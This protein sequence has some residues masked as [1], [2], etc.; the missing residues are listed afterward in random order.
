MPPLLL[1]AALAF[2]GWQTGN[3]LVGAALALA[4]EGA[5]RVTLRFDLGA[6][7]HSRIADL[8]TVVFV[9]VAAILAANRGIARGILEAFIWL[10]AAL[11]PILLAQ[12]LSESGRI[13]LSALFRYLRKMK[14]ENPAMKDPPVEVSAVFLAVA[15][16]AAGVANDRGP[17]YYAG[18][19]IAVAWA[20]YP[21]RP[22]H[23]RLAAWALMLAA[24]VG[25]GHAGH[26]GLAQLQLLVG[27]WITDWHM[28][29]MDADP[30]RTSTDIGTLGRL[31]QYD[32]IALRVYVPQKDA[33]RVRLLHRASYNSYVGTSWQARSA[34]METM[35][36][37]ADGATWLLAPAGQEWSAR[38]ATRLERGK[39]LLALP[40]G[41]TRITGLPASA[42]RRNALGAVHADVGGDWIHYEAGG[43]AAIESYAP[44]SALDEQLPPAE[45]ATLERV[46]AQLGLRD[47]TGEEAL[48]RV[49]RYLG[50]FAYSTFRERAVPR[51]ETALGDFLTRTRAGHCEYFAAAATLLLRAGGVPARYATGFAVMEYSALEAAFV[52]RARHA[53]SWTRA[54][55]GGRWIELDTTP[56]SW[57]EEEERLAPFWQGLAD[58]VRWAGFRWSQRGEF[59]AGDAWY[60]VLALL[61]AILAWRLLR[62]RR[63]VRPGQ[64]GAAQIVQSRQG[65]DSEFY[66]VEQALARRS[67][68]RPAGEALGVWVA[69]AAAGLDAARRVSLAEALG[70]HNRY[71]FDPQGLGDDERR[72]LRELGHSLA[73]TV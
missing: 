55:V 52:V 69:R 17:G 68:A 46:A 26:L 66:A 62:G 58:L 28:R 1:G 35:Q 61:A 8:C 23:A 16:V 12:M 9:G 47:A 39:T 32:T 19:V 63:V 6:T 49:Q 30:Y 3:L 59:K 18:V 42:I 72:R 15:L 20:L 53:H 11:A 45:R 56:P 43:A 71:R 5:R 54:W 10:P 33:Q 27:N 37:E 29:G 14:R 65:A 38:I 36:P 25:L 48:R 2:W 21:A 73:A 64:I 24:G 7:E 40:S 22:R 31:K 34:P 44:P 57:F 50:G 13:P 41:A 4:L 51:G 67:G 60:G 70:L